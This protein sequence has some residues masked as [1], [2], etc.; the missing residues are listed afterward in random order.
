MILF[1]LF[2]AWVKALFQLA[3]DC[4]VSSLLI[5][6]PRCHGLWDDLCFPP[7]TYRVL[8]WLWV[9]VHRVLLNVWEVNPSWPLIWTS[10]MSGWLWHL[11]CAL[12]DNIHCTLSFLAKNNEKKMK[13]HHFLKRFYLFIFRERGKGGRVGGRETSMCGCLSC[14]PYWGCGPQH[15]HVPETRNQTRDPLIHSLALHHWATPARVKHHHFYLEYFFIV[16]ISFGW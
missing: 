10:D 1:C 13:Y 5:P 4:I 16:F 11:I 3:F 12:H 6:V 14:T 9:P 8:L 2:S 15:R 7:Q